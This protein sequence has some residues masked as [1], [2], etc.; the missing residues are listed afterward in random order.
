M[1]DN[2]LSARAKLAGL[3]AYGRTPDPEV[4][5]AYRRSLATAKLDRA[6]REATEVCPGLDPA[7]V[8]HLAGLLVSWGND[9]GRAVAR[10]ERLVADAAY[11]VPG[12]TADDR[13]RIPG[14]F[15]DGGAA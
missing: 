5:A 15:L 8:G 1:S 12:L 4:E 11:C 7:Q 10:F 6:I 13:K 2:V 3:Y 14:A 9:D